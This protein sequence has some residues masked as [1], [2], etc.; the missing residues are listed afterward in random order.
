[1]CTDSHRVFQCFSAHGYNL[2]SEHILQ[3]KYNT[4]LEEVWKFVP[5]FR[6]QEPFDA[7]ICFIL[8]LPVKNP[9]KDLLHVSTYS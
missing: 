9:L 7:E 2:K 4:S 1:M 5:K 8:T 6:N 3:E